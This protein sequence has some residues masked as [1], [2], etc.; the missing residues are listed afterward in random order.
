[1]TNARSVHQAPF[2][3]YGLHARACR[4]RPMAAGASAPLADATAFQRDDL[5][6]PAVLEHLLGHLLGNPQE[7]LAAVH[8]APDVL[9][10][11]AGRDPQDDEVVEKVRAFFNDG[12][13]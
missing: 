4:P 11:N 6:A 2:D 9:G 5:T 10:T 3:C 12:V 7:P 1:M 13:A 8:L